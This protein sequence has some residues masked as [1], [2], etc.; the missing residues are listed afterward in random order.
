MRE[1]PPPAI[2]LIPHQTR[3]MGKHALQILQMN[4]N[5]RSGAKPQFEF[6]STLFTSGVRAGRARKREMCG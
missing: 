1:K 2:W 5:N 4:V 6:T 3:K